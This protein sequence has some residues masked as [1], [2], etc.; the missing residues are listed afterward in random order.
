MNKLNQN[1]NEQD[2]YS[3]QRVFSEKGALSEQRVFSEKGA[4]SAQKVITVLALLLLLV[5]VQVSTQSAGDWFVF[6]LNILEL[7]EPFSEVSNVGANVGTSVSTNVGD[8][9]AEFI[10]SIVMA[11]VL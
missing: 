11:V 9:A 10:Q 8:R 4:L 1:V 2:A 7:T 6:G 5:A 3:E